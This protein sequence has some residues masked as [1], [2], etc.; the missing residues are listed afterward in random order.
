MKVLLNG[1]ALRDGSLSRRLASNSFTRAHRTRDSNELELVLCERFVPMEKLGEGSG[2][3]VRRAFDKSSG[4]EVALKAT[5]GRRP[6]DLY[7]L[8]REYRSLVDIEHPNLVQHYD[9]FADRLRCFFTME[10]VVGM[11]IVTYLRDQGAACDYRRFRHVAAQL[12][13]AI[14]AVHSAGQLH[15][16]IKTSN[17]LVTGAGRVVLLDFGLCASVCAGNGTT[18]GEGAFMGTWGYVAPEQARGE[19]LTAAADWCAFGATLFEA[20]AGRLPF[21]DPRKVLLVGKRGDSCSRRVSEHVRR[22]PADLD[23]LIAALLHPNPAMRPDGDEVLRSLGCV[24]RRSSTFRPLED[25]PTGEL[26]DRAMLRLASGRPA[27]VHVR[28]DESG[29]HADH[30]HRFARAA[31]QRGAVVLRGRCHPRE[32]IELNA[33]DGIIDD[34]THVLEHMPRQE[35]EALLPP[36]IAHLLDLFPVMGRL[37]ALELVPPSSTMGERRATGEAERAL[38]ELLAALT[39]RRLLLVWIDDAHWGDFESGE[40]LSTVLQSPEAPASLVVLSYGSAHP[41]DDGML[42]WFEADPELCLDVVGR[43]SVTSETW[44]PQKA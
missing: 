28:A 38:S 36:G 41:I 44:P 40:L 31:Q 15:R 17:V 10:L 11:D 20:I 7:R 14:A 29:E 18:T 5:H 42:A 1:G 33:I 13:S 16:D 8:K 22:V 9:L 6:D 35:A 25:T 12:A 34:L 37:E 21:D 43:P 32:S 30:A 39:D 19:A 24:P 26:L 3:V 4:R 23:E 27:V 2:G